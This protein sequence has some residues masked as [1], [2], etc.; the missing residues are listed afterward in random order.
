M[1]RPWIVAAALLIGLVAL[2]WVARITIESSLRRTLEHSASTRAQVPVSIDAVTLSLFPGQ[3]TLHR[4]VVGNPPGYRI[5]TALTVRALAVQ[6][7][8]FSLIV[9]PLIIRELRIDAPSITLEGSPSENNLTA[10]RASLR[11]S[12]LNA[13]S[14]SHTAGG[15]T[16]AAGQ[17]AIHRVV[18]Q[19]ATATLRLHTD[20]FDTQADGIR[21]KPLLLDPFGDPP[22]TLTRATVAP[23][24]VETILRE[25]MAGLE[26]TFAQLRGIGRSPEQQAESQKR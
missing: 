23:Q 25:V 26:R 18:M 17:V 3:L 8:W 19:E 12:P 11:G 20:S 4:I 16:V 9:E 21:L 10:L 6:F 7:D 13:E 24:V 15:G 22:Q 5:P 14:V 2:T 1:R